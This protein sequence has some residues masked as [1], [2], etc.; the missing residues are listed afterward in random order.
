M[1]YK[2]VALIVAALF[3]VEC[4]EKELTR[5]K[6][7][8]NWPYNDKGDIAYEVYMSKTVKNH[9]G[10]FGF[11]QHGVTKDKAYKNTLKHLFKSL[12]WSY[13]V[14]IEKWLE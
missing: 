14:R 4:T 7:V 11:W 8:E 9:S 6:G 1:F 12:K 2:K 3:N 13:K 10:S 5:P